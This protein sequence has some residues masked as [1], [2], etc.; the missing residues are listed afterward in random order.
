MATTPALVDAVNN[1]NAALL[2]DYCAPFVGLLCSDAVPYPSTGA[3]FELAA[4]WHARTRLQQSRGA[5]IPS[6]GSDCGPVSGF[7]DEVATFDASS[8]T[9][10]ERSKQGLQDMAH[11]LPQN[12]VLSKIEQAKAR[13]TRGTRYEY[14]FKDVI[15]YSELVYCCARKNLR[16]L[17][18]RD[19]DLTLNSKWT[20]QPLINE[21]DAHFQVLPTFGV[22]PYFNTRLPWKLEELLPNYEPTQLLHGE[23]YLEIRKHPIP[24]AGKLITYPRLLRVVDKQKAAVVTTA[25]TTRDEET[26]EDIFYNESSAYIR[27]AGGY[28]TGNSL[29]I[30]QSS[31]ETHL[32]QPPIASPKRKADAIRQERTTEEQAVYYRLNGDYNAVHVDPSVARQGGFTRPILHGL[33]FFGLAGKHVFQQYG[34]I[35]NIRARFA[36]I[37]LPGQTLR[38]E[39]WRERHQVVFQMIVVETGK[40]CISDGR[41]TL[42]GCGADGQSKL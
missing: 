28:S 30:S 29:P 38:T 3:I 34:Q 1:T 25:F 13:K 37:V 5:T 31:P 10:P 40:L 39:M 42:L 27:G 35:E 32:N 21:R 24:T 41:V 19:L 6:Y 33:C 22:V 7:L 36:G 9:Y 14:N 26:G 8:S 15:L 4:G 2:A 23:Q 16:I 20:E 12:S 11:A 17:I 18:L